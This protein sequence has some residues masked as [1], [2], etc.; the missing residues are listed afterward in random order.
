MIPAVLRQEPQFRLL[1]T[2]QLLSLVGDRMM[3]VALPFAVLESGGGTGAVGLVVAAELAPFVVFSLIGGAISDRSDRRRILIGSDLGRLLVQATGAA[4]LLAGA[5]TPAMLAG[6]VLVYGTAD[7][8]FQ[9][10]FTGLLP[11]T[12]SDPV[13]LQPANA[14]R[15]LSFS[16]AAIAGP[17]L[18]GVLVATA[19]AGGA[20]LFDAGS[21][22]VSVLFLLRLRPR[23]VVTEHD[24]HPSIPP[25]SAKAGVRSSRVRG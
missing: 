15:G 8:F 22:A 12:I 4:L 2:G 24:R 6:L 20:F 10:A 3:L 9:P 18:A 23:V 21:F 14:V 17:A 13:Q 7:A 5:A 1:F 19:G 11:Q 16:A 25:R